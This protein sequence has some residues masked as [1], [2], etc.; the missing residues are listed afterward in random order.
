IP[1]PGLQDA[2]EYLLTQV[3]D[4]VRPGEARKEP[5]HRLLPAGDEIGEG[6]RVAGLPPPHPFCVL[7]A[8]ANELNAP[9]DENDDE[10]PSILDSHPDLVFFFAA[11]MRA[12]ETLA[13]LIREIRLPP[14]TQ[15][16]D[17]RLEQYRAYLALLARMQVDDRLKGKIDLS[18]VVQQTLLEAHRANARLAGRSKGEVVAWLRRALANN[19]A[20]EVRRLA[21][22]KRDVGRE[23]SLEAALQQSSARLEAWLAAEQP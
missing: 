15:D 19:L 18:G 4:P 17:R 14:V 3:R 2:K 6:R 11:R 23:R 10:K 22:G 5:G 8:H 13:Y 1:T 16:P 20:D 21:V 7:A 9:G 12:G